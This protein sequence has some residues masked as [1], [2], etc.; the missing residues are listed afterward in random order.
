MNAA[1]VA[2]IG[3]GENEGIYKKVAAEACAIDH[4]LGSC[5]LVTRSDGR[6]KVTSMTSKAVYQSQS[7]LEYVLTRININSIG[8]LYVRH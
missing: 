3:I 2:N 5:D 1:F 7:V 8:F 6:A 4:V